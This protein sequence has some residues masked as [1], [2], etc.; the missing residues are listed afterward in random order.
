NTMRY[1]LWNFDH[2][3]YAEGDVPRFEYTFD[4]FRLTKGEE[5]RGVRTNFYFI[6]GRLSIPKLEQSL[7]ELRQRRNQLQIEARRQAEKLPP[8]EAQK[9]QTEAFAQIEAD[10]IKQFG[11]VEV[12]EEV[13]DYHTQTIGD[14]SESGRTKSKSLALLFAHLNELDR[15]EP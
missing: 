9:R 4:I 13:K 11:I 2:V 3:P 7:E 14:T 1:A 15:T 8:A 10:L 12:A 6:N 5:N